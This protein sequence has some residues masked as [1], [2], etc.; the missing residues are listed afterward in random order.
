[1][2]RTL[3]TCIAL[4]MLSACAGRDPNPV[5]LSQA[6]DVQAS[7]MAMQAEVDANNK[8]IDELKSEGRWKV[9]QN[10]SAVA[11]GLLVWPALF[12]MDFKDAADTDKEALEARN[13]YL[14]NRLS[15]NDCE[16]RS[17]DAVP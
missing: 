2:K 6:Q 14:A 17:A 4:L 7:C 5:P 8:R 3:L 12:A 13:E 11:V 16:Q 1:M 15:S 9:A 10:V